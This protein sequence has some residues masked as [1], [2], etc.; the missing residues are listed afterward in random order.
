MDKAILHLFQFCTTNR[1]L[2]AQQDRTRNESLVRIMNLWSKSQIKLTS[3]YRQYSPITQQQM[4]TSKIMFLYLNT[5][6]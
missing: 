5:I 3:S 4:Q 6:P 2:T 1:L